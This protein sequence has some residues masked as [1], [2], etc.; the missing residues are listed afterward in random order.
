MRFVFT[1]FLFFCILMD[2]VQALAREAIMKPLVTRLE[3]APKTL[4]LV[5]N[6]FMYYNNGIG[7][8]VSQISRDQG[9]PINCTMATIGGAGLDWHDVKSY[10]RPNALRSYST[11]NDGSNRLVFH[12]YPDGK[13]FD[14]VILQD[15]SQGPIHPE[16]SKFFR[17]YAAIHCKDVRAAGSEPLIMMTWAYADRP[18]MT[19]QLANATIDVANANRAMVVPVGLAF[20]RAQRE[21][22]ALKLIVADNRHPTPAG[23]YLEGCVIFATL[24]GKSP[25]GARCTGVGDARISPKTALFLQ[26]VAWNTVSEFFGWNK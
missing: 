6:S 22:P 21:D 24:T 23:T 10:L 11:L 16:L 3:K 19:E 26:N 14:A 17:K 15:N 12:E 18:E 25:I 20:A 13:I 1:L 5:G 4:L 7:Q 2:P 8:Y 9:E